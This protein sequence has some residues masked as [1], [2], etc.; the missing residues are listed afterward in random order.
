M[1]TCTTHT[2]GVVTSR[3]AAPGP[4]HA[5][6]NCVPR[7]VSALHRSW[8]WF[9]VPFRWCR[10]CQPLLYAETCCEHSPRVKSTSTKA[11]LGQSGLNSAQAYLGTRACEAHARL[12]EHADFVLCRP[13]FCAQP[14]GA[15]VASAKPCHSVS[16][17]NSILVP[18]ARQGAMFTG[19]LCSQHIS[20]SYEAR[21]GYSACNVILSVA[22]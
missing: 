22:R 10:R 9:A 16:S 19:E 4:T 17:R 21:R 6:V 1:R 8:N 20:T 5:R 13:L 11:V 7:H 12:W 2:S 3:S 15:L 14:G 18:L